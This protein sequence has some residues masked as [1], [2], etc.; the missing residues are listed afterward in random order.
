MTNSRQQ[1][2]RKAISLAAFVCVGAVLLA[3][4]ARFTLIRRAT[5]REF[6]SLE[7]ARDRWQAIVE[8]LE[9][10]RNQAESDKRIVLELLALCRNAEDI[11]DLQSNRVVARHQGIEKLC[12]Y[13]PEGAHTLRIS[14]TWKPKPS[15]G[16]S[17][18]DDVPDAAGAGEKTWSMPL[19]PACGYFLEFD[20]DRKG[21]PIQWELTS[22]HSQFKTQ[23]ETVPFDG[24]SPHGSSWSGSDVLQFPNQVERFTISELEAAARVC[25][26]VKLM[27]S[28]LFG[29]CHNQP[30]ELSIDVRLVSDGPACVSAS[31]AQQIIVMGRTD[32]LLPYEGG[33]KYGIQASDPTKLAD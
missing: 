28:K 10:E 25:P 32:L 31:E 22:N 1:S 14:S 19:L 5:G 11:P 20:S 9:T 4:I 8:R 7:S 27:D 33:G 21:G 2:I 23:A 16:S 30:Y 17:T 18:K 3:F 26:G 15:S 24:F 29:Q 12:I 13:V 6:V